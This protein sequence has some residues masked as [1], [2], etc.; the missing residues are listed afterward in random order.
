MK[1]KPEYPT[2]A[3]DQERI[4]VLLLNLG[5]P[6]AP[7][8]EAVRA[9]LREFLSDTRVVE[10]PKWVWQPLLRGIVLPLRSK[11]SAHAYEKIWFKEGSPLLVFTRR[12]AEGLRRLLP[13][14]VCVEYAMTYGKPSI[15]ESID[16]LKSQGVGKLLVLPLYPQ[17]AGSSTG[18]ALDKVWR[19]ILAQRNQMS[20]CSISRFYDHPA[21][22]RA[23]AQQI[24]NYRAQ[25]GSGD[26]LMFSFHGIPQRHN[27]L[28]DPYPDECRRTAQL[29]AKELGLTEKDYVV[30]FQSRFG[31]NKWIEP[32]T[33]A[34][35]AG[36]AREEVGTRTLE[37]AIRNE[38]LVP[39]AS[40]PPAP[41]TCAVATSQKRFLG[42]RP[43]TP[44]S[45][46]TAVTS[47][48][49]WISSSVTSSLGINC[50]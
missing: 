21:Y 19:E 50:E 33:Q 5:T 9:Y 4:G 16:A 13:E 3:A 15:A 28:G 23:L 8:P 44:F 12:Q 46:T 31:K 20:V 40:P 22:I 39:V 26:L 43:P 34:L 11:K 30:S 7:K 38:P 25:H 45:F 6:S 2:H 1:F 18:A 37:A 17:Y 35:F 29:T 49:I 32:S 36:V 10:L 42:S 48:V 47:L 41:P 24:H 27:D 14:T